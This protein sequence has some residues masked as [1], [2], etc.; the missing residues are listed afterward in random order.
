MTKVLDWR[1][2]LNTLELQAKKEIRACNSSDELRRVEAKY[3][4][5]SGIITLILKAFGDM[6]RTERR[7]ENK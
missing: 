7:K 2:Q 4:G 1:R 6:M 5:K 3:L